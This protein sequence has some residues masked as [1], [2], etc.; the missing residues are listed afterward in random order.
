M[1]ILS[2]SYK[3]TRT[4]GEVCVEMD[5]RPTITVDAEIAVQHRLASGA[6]L[7]EDGLQQLVAANAQLLARRRLIQYLA[8]RRKTEAESRRYLSRHGFAEEAIDAAIEAARN[9]GYLDDQQYAEAYVRTQVRSSLK[10]PRAIRQEL[11]I[12]GVG[13]D[14]VK[15]ALAPVADSAAQKESALQ[16]AA[17]KVAEIQRKNDPVKAGLK[18]QMMLLRKGYDPD[19]ASEV[20]R[21][22]LGK[23]ED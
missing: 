5:D 20:T 23:I 1:R 22:L 15:K 14:A 6:E 18:L 11:L 2:L 3:R 7:T 17:R 13:E 12:R 4:G 21:Q 8:L 9:G 10:G 19:I 16:L